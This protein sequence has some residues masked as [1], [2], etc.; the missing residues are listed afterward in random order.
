MLSY[1]LARGAMI[2][3]NVPLLHLACF[4]EIRSFGDFEV[5]WEKD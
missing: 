2:K 1:Q 4:L 5:S 3:D